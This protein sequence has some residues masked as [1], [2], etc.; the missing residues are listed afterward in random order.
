[1]VYIYIYMNHQHKK[2]CKYNTSTLYMMNDIYEYSRISHSDFRE[3][4][5]MFHLLDFRSPSCFQKNESGFFPSTLLNLE[6]QV[7]HLYAGGPIRTKWISISIRKAYL[8][9]G[10]HFNRVLFNRISPTCNMFHARLPEMG[11]SVLFSFLTNLTQI[12]RKISCNIMFKPIHH[13]TPKESR[14]HFNFLSL[15]HVD[16]HHQQ[17]TQHH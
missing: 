11:F 1:M 6:L 3:C 10:Q 12:S 2:L 14:L 13:V 8:V 15:G 4:L 7:E 9:G 16:A 17:A 5:C